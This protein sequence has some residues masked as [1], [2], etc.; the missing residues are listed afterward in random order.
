MHDEAVLSIRKLFSEI[1]A[2]RPEYKKAI[3]PEGAFD[4]IEK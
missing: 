2:Q 3:L 4:N 1:G